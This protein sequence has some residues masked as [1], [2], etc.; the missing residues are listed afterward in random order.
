[1][2]SVP[3]SMP[4]KIEPKEPRKITW[5]SV[6]SQPAKP[7]PPVSTNQGIKKKT[8][9]APPP[10]IPG[11]HNMDIG[12]WG[13]GKASMPPPKA[14][15]PPSPPTVQPPLPSPQ[16]M[17]RQQQ[18]PPL[19][20]QQRGPATGQTMVPCWNRQPPNPPSPS[21]QLQ[22]MHQFPPPNHNVRKIVEDIFPD[23]FLPEMYLILY[24]CSKRIKPF[25]GQSSR[26][27]VYFTVH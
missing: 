14:P 16:P 15:P 2:Q 27:T 24:C 5:A 25:L 7:V 8:G 1:M 10:I 17:Q 3:I 9:I 6:A 20:Q 11:K 13:E 18:P 19:Q 4:P 21:A 12:T 22:A 23:Y 26:K